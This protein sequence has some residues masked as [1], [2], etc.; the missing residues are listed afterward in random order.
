MIV[1]AIIGAA[2]VGGVALAVVAGMF[3]EDCTPLWPTGVLA[4]VGVALSGAGFG[5][6]VGSWGPPECP[7]GTVQA[8]SRNDLLR[9]C[10]PLELARK[11]V[12]Q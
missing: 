12:E 6:M 11:Q 8:D 4:I 7:T 10:I 3:A 2:M 5:A 1:G 9:V